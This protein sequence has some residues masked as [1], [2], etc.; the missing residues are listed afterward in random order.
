MVCFIR[1]NWTLRDRDLNQTSKAAQTVVHARSICRNIIQSP[2]VICKIFESMFFFIIINV[3]VCA[4]HTISSKT[5]TANKSI[6]QSSFNLFIVIFLYFYGV[7]PWYVRY[8][9]IWNFTQT[10]YGVYAQLMKTDVYLY[11]GLRRPFSSVCSGL[12]AVPD[13][14]RSI[15]MFCVSNRRRVVGWANES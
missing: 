14:I 6:D 3:G 1:I 12:G 7:M 5:T 4:V 13:N 10:I 8:R 11:Y 2:N 15:A 9:S